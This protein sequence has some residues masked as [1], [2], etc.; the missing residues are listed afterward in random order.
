M[1]VQTAGASNVNVN[2]KETIRPYVVRAPGNV[3]ITKYNRKKGTPIVESMKHSKGSDAMV[4]KIG[5]PVYE[6]IARIPGPG[7]KPGG[8]KST[9]GSSKPGKGPVSPYYFTQPS[10]PNYVNLKP[11]NLSI[12]TVVKP[13][14]IKTEKPIPGSFPKTP[15]DQKMEEM[16]SGRSSSVKSSTKFPSAKAPSS[17]SPDSPFVPMDIDSPISPIRLS[18]VTKPVKKRAP[19]QRVGVYPTKKPTVKKPKSPDLKGEVL[20]MDLK[21]RLNALVRPTTGG[22]KRKGSVTEKMKKGIEKEKKVLSSGVKSKGALEKVK[23]RRA[24]KNDTFR[25]NAKIPEIKDNAETQPPSSSKDL[26]RRLSA[27][28]LPKSPTGQVV[29]KRR[30]SASTLPERKTNV[31]V[32]R[33]GSAKLSDK[34]KFPRIDTPAETPS[35]ARIVG[36]KRR[37]AGLQINTAGMKPYKPARGN[38][39]LQI[40]TTGMKPYKPARGNAGLQIN[41]TG[42][43]PYKPARGNAGLQINTAGMNP[44]KPR[45]AEKDSVAAE[46][47]RDPLAQ[48]PAINRLPRAAKKAKPKG[49]VKKTKRGKK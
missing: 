46:S 8:D 31:A 43:K 17:K 34:Y 23:K 36:P 48:W 14:T 40:N 27:S 41:T 21:N 6:T 45:R 24:K 3:G 12:D 37:N 35:Y 9:P 25:T 18:P 42:M 49:V 20:D 7:S 2:S 1:S 26:S 33:K 11:D 15:T 28:T 39:G 44:Y 29:V 38:A 19:R 4:K 22:V 10:Y 30:F 16:N 13:E 32:K 5:Y 47:G